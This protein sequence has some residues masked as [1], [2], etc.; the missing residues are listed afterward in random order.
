VLHLFEQEESLKQEKKSTPVSPVDE[1]RANDPTAPQSLIIRQQPEFCDQSDC[2]TAKLNTP[3]F[4]G[5]VI[6]VSFPILPPVFFWFPGCN[7]AFK[8]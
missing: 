2:K 4:V 3:S 5:F 7:Y 6:K 1:S 8:C